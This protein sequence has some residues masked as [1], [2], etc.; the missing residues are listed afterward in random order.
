VSVFDGEIFRIRAAFDDDPD[1]GPVTV[2]TSDPAGYF[3]GLAKHDL[4]PTAATV[5][6]L[7]FVVSDTD[8]SFGDYVE[9]E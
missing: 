4:S 9:G 5:H 2:Y 1:L 8:F 3:A 7:N 6:R